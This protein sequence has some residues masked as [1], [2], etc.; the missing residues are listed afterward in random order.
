MDS[1]RKKKRLGITSHKLTKTYMWRLIAASRSIDVELRRFL[2][3]EFRRDYYVFWRVWRL[4][5]ILWT[6]LW[7]CVMYD[8]FF[9]YKSSVFCTTIRRLTWNMLTGKALVNSEP[10]S[11]NGWP[12][13]IRSENGTNSESG[14]THSRLRH[15]VLM[16]YQYFIIK[17][18]S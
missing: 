11:W 1:Q 16:F 9:F 2:D 6:R 3:V 15:N 13:K 7:D 10:K 4:S 17:N 12:N 8:I 5:D 18:N 14:L